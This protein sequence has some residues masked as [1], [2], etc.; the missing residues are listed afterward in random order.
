MIF[1][2]NFII[3]HLRCI[4]VGLI[5]IIFS[6][7]NFQSY[8]IKNVIFKTFLLGLMFWVVRFTSISIPI[9]LHFYHLFL[10]KFT[11]FLILLLFTLKKIHQHP[12]KLH[13]FYIII[14]LLI[15]NFILDS[16]ITCRF[17]STIFSQPFYY[18][19]LLPIFLI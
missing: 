9:S 7:I 3:D 15:T 6:F 13:K 1:I 8:K 16:I 17:D 4:T 12:L 10:T 19:T 14:I 2:I 11:I 5:L 18:L